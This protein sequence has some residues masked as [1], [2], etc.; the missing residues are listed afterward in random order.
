[1]TRRVNSLNRPATTPDLIERQ[2]V[3]LLRAKIAWTIPGAGKSHSVLHFS[4]N[5]ESAPVQADADDVATKVATFLTSLRNH[6]PGT[7]SLQRLADVEEINEA[8]GDLIGVFSTTT[9]AAASGSLPSTEKWAA[10][11]GAVITW[12]TAGIRNGRRVRGRTFLVPLGSSVFDTD[13]TIG[14]TPMNGINSLSAAL[15]AASGTTS[16]AVW[17]RPSA[18]GATDGVA[19]NVLSHKVPDM[20]AVLTTRRS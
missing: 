3:G 16:L 8:T 13:G 10:P 9:T 17:G 6:I 7:I 15:Y 11:V 2:T 20:A 4:T 18:P 5:S 14:T 1:M 19:Y 12:T